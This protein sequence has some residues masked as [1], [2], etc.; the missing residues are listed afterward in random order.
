MKMIGQGGT[1]IP[2]RITDKPEGLNFPIL[3]TCTLNISSKNVKQSPLQAPEGFQ[4]G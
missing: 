3:A 4:E 1:I 2:A